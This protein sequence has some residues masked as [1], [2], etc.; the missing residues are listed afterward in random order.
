MSENRPPLDGADLD[1]VRACHCRIHEP[2]GDESSWDEGDRKV[3]RDVESHGWHALS[4]ASDE[5]VP[6]WTFSIG[7]WHSLG[8]PELAILAIDPGDGSTVLTTL[9]NE[10]RAGNTIDIGSVR[11]DLLLGGKKV[12]FRTIDFSWYRALFGY[13][14][15]FSWPPLPFTQIVWSDGFGR[16]PWD[17]D[18]DPAY[19]T[20]Q[21]R[22]WLPT[23]TRPLG[24]W[25]AALAPQPWPFADAPTTLV[26]TTTRIADSGAPF[27]GVVHQLDGAWQFLDG[28][29]T[30]Q[31]DVALLHLAHVV[32]SDHTL[33][34]LADLAP[35]WEA[36][37]SDDDAQWLRRPIA[38]DAD[39]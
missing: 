23:S 2:R 19:L 13:A 9:V 31:V 39:P 25:S 22:L 12:A 32:G 18:A 27:L 15:W 30:T 33:A 7:L 3:V 38:L 5:L 21:P 35:G 8:S 4:V 6:G 11:D 26:S 17:S 37:R 20:R 29:S 24:R 36:W 10:I 14:L 28:G 16:F 1:R 34:E